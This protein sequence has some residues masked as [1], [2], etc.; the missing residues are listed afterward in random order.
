MRAKPGRTDKAGFP[1]CTAG[2]SARSR[3]GLGLFASLAVIATAC[4]D[5]STG[6]GSD[7]SG[8]D[9]GDTLTLGYSAWPGW[10]PLAVTEEAGIFDEVGLDV[11]LVFFTDYLEALDA[12]AA[13][14]LD[15][16]GQTLND[17][18]VSVSAGDDQRIV[19]VGDNSA[20][21]DAIIVDESISSIEDLEGTTIA[22][23]AG[24][25]D[26]FLLLQ[27]LESVGMAEN[28]VDFRSVPTEQ[29]A[30]GFAGGE[31]DGVGVFAPFTLQAL[32][33][34]GSHVLFDSSEFPGTIPDHFVAT[35]ELVEDRPEDVQLLVDAWYATLDY[36]EA[37]PDEA[38]EI[39]AEAA[40]LTVEEYTTLDEGTH[41]F[42]AEEAL[43][44]F[45]S[46]EMPTGLV[47]MAEEINQFLVT[48]E[49]SQTEAPLD[50]LFEPSF[51]ADHL[52]GS[53]G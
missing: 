45:E 41:L 40:D 27:G 33:R 36:I 39:M 26:H 17:T 47:P 49:L 34:E 19:I 31:F 51:T 30:A 7:A 4:G 44:A 3:L 48:T 42:S 35:A 8:D 23:E 21:N 37:N 43:E 52:D 9:A 18:I 24:V 25:V 13:G 11:E 12:M 38:L 50:N 32:D 29:A 16:N 2:W 28:D 5:D 53:G 20:G 6:D 46:D 22:A 15:V 10:F 14:Q 1:S